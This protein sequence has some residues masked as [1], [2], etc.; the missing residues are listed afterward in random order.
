MVVA[1]VERFAEF[2]REVVTGL[3][4]QAGW[5]GVFAQEDPEG[6]RACLQGRELP[7]WDVVESLLSDTGAHAGEPAARARALHAAAIAA[8]DVREG[9]VA[10]L[11]ARLDAMQQELQSKERDLR[12]V[13]AAL[14]QAASR[15]AHE[16]L[17]RE[18]AWLQD[19]RMRATARCE[20]LRGRMAA[21]RERV[22][23][24]YRA[25]QLP[26]AGGL[27]AERPAAQRHAKA[28][29]PRG[30][31]FAGVDGAA[32]P[33]PV[34]PAMGDGAAVADAPSGGGAGGARFAGAAGGAAT[35]TRRGDAKRAEAARLEEEER[36]AE[37][38]DAAA[39]VERIVRLR[40][41][42]RTGEAYAELTAAAAGAANRLPA[43]VS[44]LER[45]GL[46]ADTSTLLWEAGN[47][48]ALRLAAT[49]AALATSGHPDAAAQLL[50]QS[51]S[52]P[53]ADLATITRALHEAGRP[54]ELHTLLVAFIQTRTADEATRLALEAPALLVPHL[55]TAAKSASPTRHHALTS[56]LRS[57]GVPGAG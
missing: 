17:A 55:L 19:D 53:P 29:R 57:A 15:E 30:A 18:Q 10:E 34:L 11:A 51:V 31:R 12:E 43:L 27:A 7:P 4:P 39:A 38:R 13:H 33:P 5:Y 9:S 37:R 32:V 52:R 6:L 40:A 35:R 8:W 23:V 42:G 45:A 21:L 28:A 2:L 46:A 24:E 1:E 36:V 26:A 44:A 50:R 20:E 16:R 48:P 56:A 47:Q 25:E 22:G 14:A 41:A 49:A 3:D 54:A